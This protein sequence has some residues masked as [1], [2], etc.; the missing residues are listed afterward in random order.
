MGLA[1]PIDY[2]RNT[3]TQAYCTTTY[4]VLALSIWTI[5]STT[6]AG[7]FHMQQN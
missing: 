1:Y 2:T 4:L 7:T 6:I 5:Y 3:P